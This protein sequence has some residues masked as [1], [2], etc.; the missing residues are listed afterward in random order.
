M[1][2]FRFQWQNVNYKYVGP[3]L[4]SISPQRKSKFGRQRNKN[5]AIFAILISLVSNRR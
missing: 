2:P 3:G 4:A 5:I 1:K